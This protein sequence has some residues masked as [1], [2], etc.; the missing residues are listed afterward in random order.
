MNGRVLV[1]VAGS[2]LFASS[3]SAQP[4]SSTQAAATCDQKLTAMRRARAAQ[5]HGWFSNVLNKQHTEISDT[6]CRIFET[7]GSDRLFK[8]ENF[9]RTLFTGEGFH[10]SVSSSL[11]PGSGFAAGLSFQADHALRSRPVRLSGG[12][13]ARISTNQ[14]WAFAGRFRMLGS[15]RDAG[16]YHINALIEFNKRHLAH[17]TDFGPGNSSQLAG[18]KAFALDSTGFGGA[19]EFPIPRGGFVSGGLAAM[20]FQPSVGP[21]TDY[22]VSSGELRWIYPVDARL[23]GYSAQVGASLRAFHETSGSPYSFR[24]TEVA[25]TN[26]YT[27]ALLGT[28]RVIGLATLSSTGGRNSVPYYLQPTMGGSNLGG[29]AIL[30][31]F[32]DYRFRGPNAL[33]VLFEH[34]RPIFDPIGSFVFADLGQVSDTVSRFAWSRW[35]K[36]YGAGV[37]VRL[38]AVT[39]FK[40]FYAWGGGEGT[41]TTFTGGSD[42]FVPKL[43]R[44]VN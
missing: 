4:G 17:L 13:D 27:P 9:G 18:E 34:E 11:V 3:T 29:H 36:S 15:D 35:H 19:I 33:A 30:R 6:W 23:S 41:R 31:S 24:Q 12:A 1:L 38:G 8:A 39:I 37:S 40:F 32:H 7:T 14:S 43:P 10:P 22:V 44:L 42:A 16:K 25:W 21:P 28:F 5:P 2:V 26:A 20:T